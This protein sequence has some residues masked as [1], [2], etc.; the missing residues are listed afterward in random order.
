MFFH[1]GP[2]R[3][4]GLLFILGASDLSQEPRCGFPATQYP[5][6]F[7]GT[8]STLRDRYLPGPPGFP[9]SHEHIA[10]VLGGHGGLLRPGR[11]EKKKKRK[12]SGSGLW[13][14]SGFLP[15]SVILLGIPLLYEE[16][17]LWEAPSVVSQWV[18]FPT[19]LIRFL[20]L[21]ETFLVHVSRCRGSVDPGSPFYFSD[22]L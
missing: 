6:S 10:G 2:I 12:S 9:K 7:W 18:P 1:R 15:T 11:E 17:R 3:A 16:N 22:L 5:T 13:D 14:H 8:M 4:A 19:A 21:L 20:G